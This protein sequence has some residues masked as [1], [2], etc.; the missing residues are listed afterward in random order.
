[1]LTVITEMFG[2]KGN[3]GDM[4][5]E[6]KLRKE[7][8]QEGKAGISMNFGKRR[9]HIVYIN[10]A[11]KESGEYQIASVQLDG[12]KLEAASVSLEEIKLLEEHVTHELIVELA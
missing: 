9:W 7:Q 5:L 4:V 2:V 6:P 10:K 12:K 11:G 1:M 8:F 3:C